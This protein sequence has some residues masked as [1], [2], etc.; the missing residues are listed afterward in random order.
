MVS[1]KLKGKEELKIHRDSSPSGRA[2]RSDRQTGGQ[3]DYLSGTSGRGEGERPAPGRGPQ[4][5]Q[6]VGQLEAPGE[7]NL[8]VIRS[9]P[10]RLWAEAQLMEIQKAIWEPHRKKRTR[11]FPETQMSVSALI[12]RGTTLG[13]NPE[14]ASLWDAEQKPQQIN[15]SLTG[16]RSG[17]APAHTPTPPHLMPARDQTHG[18]CRRMV[19]PRALAHSRMFCVPRTK[20]IRQMKK[21][22]LTE[23]E[24]DEQ[25]K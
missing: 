14:G 4:T 19:L 10:V 2:G 12:S 23:K 1:T 16:S 3:H 8:H 11:C 21:H 9:A 7:Q 22:H 25:Q 17:A 20:I 15:Q 5:Q 6:G 13:G 24:N 18:P